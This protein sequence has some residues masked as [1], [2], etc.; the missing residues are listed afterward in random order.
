MRKRLFLVG[1]P[2]AHVERTIERAHKLNLE[3]ILG[4]NKKS[5]S[6]FHE[7]IQK[8]DR[9]IEVDY[10]DYTELSDVFRELNEEKKVDLIFSFKENALINVAKIANNY[11]LKGLKKEIIELCMSKYRTRLILHQAGV[12][13]PEFALCK[14]IN[15][16]KSFWKKLNGPMIIKP[17]NLQGSLGVI[18]IENEDQ[19]EFAYSKC[20][21]NC[22]EKEVLVEEFIEG[23]EVSIEAMV[24]MGEIIVFGITEKLLYANSFVE[25]GHISPYEEGGLQL[26]EYKDIVKNIVNVLGINFGPLHI[27]GF[28]NEKG[29]IA[30]EVHNRYGGDNITTLTENSAKCDMTSPI[31]AEL[32]EISYEISFG[33]PKEFTA[34]RFLSSHSGR[35]IDV[36]GID[37]L[38]NNPNLIDYNIKCKVGDYIPPVTSS[39][40]R[41]GWILIKGNTKSQ[42]EINLQEALDN[43]EILIKEDSNE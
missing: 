11:N 36:K 15:E 21:E 6:E 18:K 26:E 27:E 14:D 41:I 28:L 7:K 1:V 5:L 2:E 22:K 8:V 17:D 43:I 29:F 23:K 20:L 9:L 13:S 16:V 25:M 31:L 37:E 38:K 12:L 32:A 3:I 34:I 30:G 19:I 4:D 10:Q 33:T 42:L 40:D 24:Y 39:F 35:V